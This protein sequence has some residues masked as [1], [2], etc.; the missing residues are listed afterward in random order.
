MGDQIVSPLLHDERIRYSRHILVPEI[1]FEGQE[2][3]RRASVTVVGAGGLGSPVLLYLTAAGVGH[4]TIIDDDHVDLSNLQRQVIH[5][6]TDI[7][8]PKVD[9]AAETLNAINPNTRISVIPSRVTEDNA[10]E[11]LRNSEVVIDATDNFS[12]RYVIS[13]AA[14]ILGVPHIWASVYRFEGTISVFHSRQG[15]E[16]RDLYPKA[17]PAALAPSCSEAGVLGATCGLIGSMMAME[18]IKAILQIGQ[19]IVGR[20]LH[21]NTLEFKITE[22]PVER[23]NARPETTSVTDSTG[24]TCKS[25]GTHIQQRM[26]PRELNELMSESDGDLTKNA[27]IDVREQNEWEL[28]HIEGTVH[29]PMK[30]LLDAEGEKFLPASKNYII[31]CQSGVRS[32]QVAQHLRALGKANVYDVEGGLNAITAEA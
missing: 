24:T 29:V 31:L 9:S 17:P 21:I 6:T 13:D 30:M 10:L 25:D 14:A 7:G 1:G 28:F 4:I 22:L 23:D 5:G 18:A 11:L 15:L 32:Q 20:F 2:K 26:S 19:L 12:A 8:R 27:I 3:L 16:Y